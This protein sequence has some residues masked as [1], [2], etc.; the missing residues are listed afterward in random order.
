MGQ[1]LHGI[2]NVLM[3]GKGEDSTNANEWLTEHNYSY[4]LLYNVKE[5]EK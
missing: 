3:H 5:N 1:K 2:K 4:H